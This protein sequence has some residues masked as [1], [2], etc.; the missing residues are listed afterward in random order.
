MTNDD[1]NREEKV[2]PPPEYFLDYLMHPN[3]LDLSEAT[4]KAITQVGIKSFEM[5]EEADLST[6]ENL[7]DQFAI[8]KVYDATIAIQSLRWLRYFLRHQKRISEP[9]SPRAY[10][11]DWDD[12][13][14]EATQSICT[15][16]EGIQGPQIHRYSCIQVHDH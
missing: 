1:D 10:G 9:N 12:G 3:C 5:L 11:E 13:D 2:V 7:S 8:M 16:G 14:F 4:A 6:I 15:E